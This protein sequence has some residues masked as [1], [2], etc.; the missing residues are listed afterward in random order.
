[1]NTRTIHKL[2]YERGRSIFSVKCSIFPRNPENSERTTSKKAVIF[3]AVMFPVQIDINFIRFPIVEAIRN[4]LRILRRVPR[5]D[6]EISPAK[7][8]RCG[9]RRPS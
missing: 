4:A 6:G 7:V 9:R 3:S 5:R 1:M 2:I 8:L